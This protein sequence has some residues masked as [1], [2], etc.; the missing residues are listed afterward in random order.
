MAGHP[1]GGMLEVHGAHAALRARFAT[2]PDVVGGVLRV[3][4][5]PGLGFS[6]VD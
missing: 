2:H 1:H 5:A 6:L 4:D 3:P